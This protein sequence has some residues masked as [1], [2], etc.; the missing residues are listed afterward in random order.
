[1]I[2]LIISLSVLGAALI[3]TLCASYYAYKSA[4]WSRGASKVREY[5]KRD[6]S[7]PTEEKINSL[8]QA[9]DNASFEDVYITS[10]DGLRLHGKLYC[11][12]PLSPV[13]IFMH[14]YKGNAMRSMYG[15]FKIATDLGHNVLIVDMRGCNESEGR[16][17]TF[18][19]KERY[20]AI[21][22]ANYIKERFSNPCVYLVGI[23]LGGASVL[24]ANNGDLPDCVKGVVADCP[25][26]SPIEILKKVCSDKK[27]PRIFFPFVILG[28][29]IFAHFN[30]YSNS[31]TKSLKNQKAPVLLI[32]GEADRFV[33]FAM[34]E[35]IYNACTG[36][37]YLY[38]IKEAD[39]ALCY[40]TDPEGYENAVISF[41][42][43]HK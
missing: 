7:S 41:F 11:S 27:I 16:A 38:P 3:F 34:S 26:N 43:K 39:H 14:G 42:E 19:I 5:F 40:I 4:F 31:A 33:P 10:F 30:P 20:D 1:M 8:C 2:G 36:E 28:A 24:M 25:F 9:L 35:E 6:K 21:T 18:G 23:S 32:H 12:N 37:R 13:E 17:V 29:I 22:W 15:S